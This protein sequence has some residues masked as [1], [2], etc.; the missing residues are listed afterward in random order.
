MESVQ[1]YGWI[2]DAAG[3]EPGLPCQIWSLLCSSFSSCEI[4]HNSL[5]GSTLYQGG[6]KEG[7]GS[8][9]S[10]LTSEGWSFQL[11]A[12]WAK[13]KRD[14]LLLTQARR[15]L[16]LRKGR[17][18]KE[19]A[20]RVRGRARRTGRGRAEIQVLWELRTRRGWEPPTSIPPGSQIQP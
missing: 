18:K 5:K 16:H 14:L 9:V 3:M 19:E 8:K 15:R 1:T 17:K 11:K 10:R 20:E 4:T 6:T 13:S 7:G 12:F 2:T